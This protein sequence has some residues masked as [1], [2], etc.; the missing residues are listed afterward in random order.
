MEEKWHTYPTFMEDDQAWISFNQG[1]AEVADQDSRNYH[2]RIRVRFRDQS[3]YGLPTDEEFDA[4][5]ALDELLDNA[6]TET[7]SI[8]IGRVAV[9]GHRYFF[10][11]TS[12]TEERCQDIIEQVS[13]TTGYPLEYNLVADPEKLAYWEDLYPTVDDWQVIYD[14]QVLDQLAEAG[15]NKNIEREIIHWAYFNSE[16]SCQEFAIWATEENY[17]VLDQGPADQSQDYVVKFAHMGTTDLWDISHHS[18]TLNRKA[19]ELG[20]EYDGWQ[21][22]AEMDA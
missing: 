14:L 15:D 2:L 20:G 21:T 13:N 9:A 19:S 17:T 5:C 1:F 7:G 10:F 3:P 18:V 8:Y 6:L 11:Y 16:D 12:D 22:S 4:L